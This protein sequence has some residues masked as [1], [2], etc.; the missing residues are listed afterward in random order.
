MTSTSTPPPM[1]PDDFD[2]SALSAYLD[3]EL[4]N[5]ER[6]AV[7]RRVA[8]DP[9]AR[10]MLDELRVTREA[11]RALPPVDAPSGFWDRVLDGNATTDAANVVPLD[12]A[13]ARSVRSDRRRRRWLALPSAAAAAVFVAVVL[14]PQPKE[15]KP[16]LTS[17][18]ESHAERSS[19]ENDPISNLAPVSADPAP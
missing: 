4:A 17:L 5:A 9:V 16:Q 11:V 18:T 19:V 14:V 13:R 7:E 1:P 8:A 2:E 15:I 12:A 10:T 6:A 3:G